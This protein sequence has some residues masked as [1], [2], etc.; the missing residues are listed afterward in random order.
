MTGT[1]KQTVQGTQDTNTA[2]VG[3][4]FHIENTTRADA[5]KFMDMLLGIGALPM[6]TLEIS[7]V[8][9]PAGQARN[10]QVANVT[11]ETTTG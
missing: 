10:T 11:K 3:V 5:Q 4:Q 9:F 6:V 2:R 1:M 8:E 7:S